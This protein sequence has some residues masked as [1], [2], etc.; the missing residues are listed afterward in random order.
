MK[1]VG[2]ILTI[3]DKGGVCPLMT[4]AWLS[5]S[6]KMMSANISI[7]RNSTMVSSAFPLALKMRRIS[8]PTL[9]KRWGRKSWVHNRLHTSPMY[10]ELLPAKPLFCLTQTRWNAI[11]HIPIMLIRLIGNCFMLN[12]KW[13]R[14]LIG[15]ESKFRVAAR[16][17]RFGLSAQLYS[18]AEITA[19]LSAAYSGC[20]WVG[21]SC[22]VRAREYKLLKSLYSRAGFPSAIYCSLF[23]SWV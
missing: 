15:A 1:V 3:T 8:S 9:S 21:N 16:F 14:F 2:V 7:R 17:D 13:R 11:I 20:F 6:A 12:I 18:R 10:R 23:R 19:R 22:F 5:F 4:K